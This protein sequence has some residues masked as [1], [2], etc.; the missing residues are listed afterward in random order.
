MNIVEI[1]SSKIV[2]TRKGRGLSW[3]RQWTFRVH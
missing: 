3:T 2:L 1:C